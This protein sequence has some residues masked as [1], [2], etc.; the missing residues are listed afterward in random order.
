[1]RDVGREQRGVTSGL[2]NLSRK[3]GLITGASLMG[4]I[5]ALAARTSDMAAAPP[6]VVASGMRAT[7][8]VAAALLAAALVFTTPKSSARSVGP[9]SS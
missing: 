2:L 4:A 1:M 7:F 5:F 3:L 9:V 8:A 6:A